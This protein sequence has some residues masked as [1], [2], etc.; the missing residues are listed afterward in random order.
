MAE[1][2][3][4]LMGDGGGFSLDQGCHG[5]E[6]KEARGGDS[7]GPVTGTLDTSLSS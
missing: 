3:A 5:K 4:V 7:C 6:S 2:A 1:E